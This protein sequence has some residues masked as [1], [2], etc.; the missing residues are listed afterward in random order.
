MCTRDELIQKYINIDSK[1][2][3]EK[4]EI[5]DKLKE[6]NALNV[7][8]HIVTDSNLCI[9]L[10]CPGEEELM[11]DKVCFGETGNNLDFVLN[12]LTNGNNLIKGGTNSA[13][14]GG[15]I[16][17]NFS[18]FN[19]SNKVYFREYNEAEASDKEILSAENKKRLEEELKQIQQIDYFI[20]CGEKAKL[21]YPLI[22]SKYQ[23]AK[24]SPVCHLG[25]V[26]IRNEYKNQKTQ[27]KN[28]K[29]LS[30]IEES[31]RDE[32]RLKIIADKIREDFLKDSD[33]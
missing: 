5:L 10:S 13:C 12:I 30:D 7:A 3:Q 1:T 19:A 25:N 22:S 31:K 21:L 6:K 16:R 26:G 14:N 8:D 11:H 28:G 23:S 9:I 17:Y 32:E 29:F 27:L 33:I 2:R 15:K 24:I 20:L 4:K 18:I